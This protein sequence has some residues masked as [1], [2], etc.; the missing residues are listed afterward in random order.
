VITRNALGVWTLA[1]LA[2]VASGFLVATTNHSDDFTVRAAISTAVGVVFVAAG[3]V[4]RARR[5]DNRTGTIMV[6]TGF[7]WFL[8][9]LTQ[10]NDSILFT[11]GIGLNDLPWAF[12][13]WLVLAYPTG[14]LVGWPSKV[15]VWGAFG[16]TLLLRPLWA[17]FA[18][19]YEDHPGAPDNALFVASHKNAANVILLAEQLIAI[20][21][22]FGALGILLHRWRAAAPALRRT[23]SPVFLTFGLT[24][25]LLATAVLMDVFSIGNQQVAYIIALGALLAVP[26]GF[27]AGL[28]QT[29]LARGN[30]SRLLVELDDAREPGDLRDAIARAL[31]DPSLDLAYWLPEQRLFV[32]AHGRVVEVPTDPDGPRVATV[33][34]RDGHMVAVLVHDRSLLEDTAIL[35]AVGAAA[36]LALENE[37]RLT[38]LSRTEARSRALLDA[39]PDVMV[40]VDRKGTYLDVHSHREDDDLVA[41]D[42]Q[43]VGRTLHQVIP[44]EMADRLL[45]AIQALGPDS[46]AATVE[47]HLDVDGERHTF[48]SRIAPLGEDEAILVVREITDRKRREDQV[49]QLEAELEA[50]LADLQRERELVRAVVQSA[51]SFFCLVDLEGRVTRFNVALERASGILDDDEVRSRE[52]WEIFVAPEDRDEVRRVVLGAAAAGQVTHERES[53]WV[54]PDGGTMDVAWSVSPLENVGPVENRFLIT[55]I[56]VT[57]RKRQQAQLRQSRARIV[58]AASTERRRLERNLHDGAQQRL[59]SLSLSLRLAQARIKKDPAGAEQLL[60]AAGDELAHALEELRE[61]ARGIHPAILTDRGL[62]PALQALL[63]RAPVDVTLAEAP[64]ERL[65]EAVEAAAYYVVAEAVTNVVKYAKASCATVRVVRENGRA[66]VEVA[67]D[68][69]GGADASQGSGLRGLADRVEALDGRLNVRSEPGN[70]TTIRAEIPVA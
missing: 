53:R 27:A 69:I 34:E 7:A 46:P 64:G 38:E 18:D 52:F 35:D 65:P 2:A 17:M 42:D 19:V 50:R 10:A 58:E 66:V 60:N 39:L 63:S 68:G 4:V 32:G 44:T 16:A 45:E 28:L 6:L 1:L 67:D 14:R 11:A 56:D 57:D 25:V 13:G 41:P 51:P 55:G 3:L 47:Y 31:G 5:P 48:E 43:L 21:L 40:R 15:L 24:V 22:I 62:E 33:V 29:R 36:G 26:L 37:R 8:N 20:G 23:L 61:L 59:V 70:G 54:A 9:G 49:Q 12:F 30:V